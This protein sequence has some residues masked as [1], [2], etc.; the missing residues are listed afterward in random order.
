MK[1]S[2]FSDFLWSYL[3]I[4]VQLVYLFIEPLI[5][6]TVGLIMEV[7]W[8]YYLISIGGYYALTAVWELIAYF[9]RDENGKTLHSPFM[10]KLNGILARFNQNAENN[11]KAETVEN[12][13]TEDN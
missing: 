11:P 3:F 4:L 2:R 5:F 8:Q 9:L 10:R 7:S 6:S 13:P 1:K 12:L